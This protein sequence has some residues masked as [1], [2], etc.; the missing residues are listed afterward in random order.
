MATPTELGS[1]TPTSASVLASASAAKS[2]GVA[3]EAITLGHVVYKDATTGKW[4]KAKARRVS[5]GVAS[6]AT[7]SPLGIALTT[8]SQDAQPIV[9]CTADSA[10]THGY[11]DISM[12]GTNAKFVMM[13]SGAN[14]GG[15]ATVTL[16]QYDYPIVLGVLNGTGT[17]MIFSPVVGTGIL[18]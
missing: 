1:G 18:A 8:A 13:L 4:L 2:L 6:P 14:S 9:V 11:S 15:M 5:E 12:T 17:T 16:A 7:Y 10:F 3:G